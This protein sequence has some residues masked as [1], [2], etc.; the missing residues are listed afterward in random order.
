MTD[1]SDGSDSR[2]STPEARQT[3]LRERALQRQRRWTPPLGLWY[4]SLAGAQLPRSHS[5]PTG[6]SVEHPKREDF[7]KEVLCPKVQQ[8]PPVASVL[9]AACSIAKSDIWET[10]KVN[11]P[12]IGAQ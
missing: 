4:N 1:G 12:F 6:L 10:T 8:T 5:Q 9:I 3:H 7:P 2:G 11:L